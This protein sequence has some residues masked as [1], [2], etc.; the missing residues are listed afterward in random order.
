MGWPEDLLVRQTRLCIIMTLTVCI[1]SVELLDSLVGIV[2]VLVGDKGNAVGA[3]SL[4]VAQ[5]QS[6]NGANT[7]E[8]LLQTYEYVS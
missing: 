2:F 5:L 1:C 3:A 8:E 4:V 6:N 7:F